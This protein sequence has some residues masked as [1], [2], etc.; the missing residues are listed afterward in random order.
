[1]GSTQIPGS[2][3]N[4]ALRSS[5]LREFDPK[6]G[7]LG[8]AVFGG[9]TLSV[10]EGVSNDLGF[11]VISGKPVPFKFGGF[12]AR[13]EPELGSTSRYF[14]DGVEQLPGRLEGWWTPKQVH[15]R[16]GFARAAELRQK[17]ANFSLNMMTIGSAPGRGLNAEGEQVPPQNAIGR[18]A[19]P[20]RIR[21]Y[22]GMLHDFD[23]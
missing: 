1:V 21:R 23:R 5:L 9:E 7:Q 4:E 22:G 13:N 16:G 19:G 14:P 8:N 17:R 11:D 6:L 2:L 20:R 15:E 18:T 3:G 12:K 10:V